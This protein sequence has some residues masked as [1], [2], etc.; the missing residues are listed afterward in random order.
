MS[1]QARIGSNIENEKETPCRNPDE[2]LLIRIKKILE[3]MTF[4]SIRSITDMLNEN[5]NIAYRYLTG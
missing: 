2:Q 3:E 4:S 5:D 1:A